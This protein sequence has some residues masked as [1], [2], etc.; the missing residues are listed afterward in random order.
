MCV[1]A[2]SVISNS[3]QPPGL[4]PD[5]FL[6]PWNFPDKNTGVGCHFLLQRIFPKSGIE[7]MSSVSPALQTDSLL[8]SHHGS[9]EKAMVFAQSLSHVWSLWPHEL[10]NARL[11]FPSLS[12]RVCSNSCPLSWWCHPTT[13]SSVPNLPPAINLSQHQDLFP[14]VSCLYQVAKV[15]E[16]QPQSFQWIFRTDFL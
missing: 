2:C 3:L 16:L 4:Q 15:L 7:P 5:R 6:C 13:S 11:P 14:W 8:L 10:Q 1:H 12:L 9:P